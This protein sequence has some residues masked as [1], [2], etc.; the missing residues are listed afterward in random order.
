MRISDWSSDVCSSDLPMVLRDIAEQLGIHESTV[1]RATA[2]KYMLTPRGLYELKFFFS[3]HVQTTSGGV[4]SAT[5]IQAMI[6]RMITGENAS[7]PLSDA[8]LSELLDRKSVV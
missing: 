3:S 5:A 7:R 4:C 1:S 6:K 8:T 2:N